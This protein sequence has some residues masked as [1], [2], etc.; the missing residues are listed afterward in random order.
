MYIFIP[1]EN[2]PPELFQVFGP[3]G[4]LRRNQPGRLFC[5]T[6]QHPENLHRH[7]WQVLTPEKLLKIFWKLFWNDIENN[8]LKTFT[9]PIENLST[10]CSKLCEMNNNC[11]FWRAQWDGTLCHLLSSDYQHVSAQ[12]TL[13][14]S[15]L[16]GLWILCRG[17]HC[18]G[19][20]WG[21]RLLLCLCWGRLCLHWRE[22]R[23]GVEGVNMIKELL[24]V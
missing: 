9:K 4:S 7:S 21:S 22:S 20:H 19:L 1:S 13:L 16:P 18:E 24:L 6:R 5:G 23:W 2:K 17:G 10:R 14:Q 3:G 8:P 12:I 15:F 11:E